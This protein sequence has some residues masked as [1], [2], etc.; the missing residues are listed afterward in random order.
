MLSRQDVLQDEKFIEIFSRYSDAIG[1][2]DEL[3]LPEWDRLTI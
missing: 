2:K 1:I 3:T